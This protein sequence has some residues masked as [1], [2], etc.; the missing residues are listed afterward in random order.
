MEKHPAIMSLRGEVVIHAGKFGESLC[1]ADLQCADL[2]GADLRGADLRRA[3]LRGADL[4]GANL[5]C[6]DLRRADLR[7]ADLRGADLQGANL[8]CADLQGANL[9]CA[10]LTNVNLDFSCWPLWCGSFDV[11]ISMR[12]VYQL[13]YHICRL[14]NSSKTFRVIKTILKPYANRFHRI[15]RDVEKIG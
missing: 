12:H 1:G 14:R 15:G 10:D 11:K 13:C 2:W 6:A 9:Q 5:Q 8:Q 4:Q 7:G 3:D